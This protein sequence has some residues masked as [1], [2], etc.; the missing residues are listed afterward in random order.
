MVRWFVPL[1]ADGR[2]M[3]GDDGGYGS[4]FMGELVFERSGS[5]SEVPQEE[6]FQFADQLGPPL[7]GPA[8]RKLVEQQRDTGQPRPPREVHGNAVNGSLI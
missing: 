2:A 1:D 7:L 4:M 3:P 6:L 5:P 8:L